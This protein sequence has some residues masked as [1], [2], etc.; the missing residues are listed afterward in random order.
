MGYR[1]FFIERF[2]CFYKKQSIKVCSKKDGVTSLKMSTAECQCG[3]SNNWSLPLAAMIS[4]RN[5]NFKWYFVTWEHK[6]S[7]IKNINV[8]RTMFPEQG[9]WSN[10]S[11]PSTKDSSLLPYETIYAVLVA[12]YFGFGVEILYN[13]SNGYFGN[14]FSVDILFLIFHNPIQ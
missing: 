11:F 2:S 13:M 4:K 7:R 12:P 8:A 14:T 10:S 3:E 6:C 9:M 1:R 5:G